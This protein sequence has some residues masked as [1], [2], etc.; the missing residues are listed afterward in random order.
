[1]H[2]AD[3]RTYFLQGA[4][5]TIHP[6]TL[7]LVNWHCELASVVQLPLLTAP[8]V[9]LP[10]ILGGGIDDLGEQRARELQLRS[11]VVH[12]LPV[13]TMGLAL[14][15]DALWT[16]GHH[17]MCWAPLGHRVHRMV[18]QRTRMHG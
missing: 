14:R 13:G 18:V 11:R 3:F 15:R 6:L 10:T 1:M 9:S 4:E 16:L 8:R 7:K 12:H 2:D 5:T 17:G